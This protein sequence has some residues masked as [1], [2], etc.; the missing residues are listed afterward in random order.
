MYI[1][2]SLPVSAHSVAI[3][4]SCALSLS[5][6]SFA[7]FL[8]IFPFNLFFTSCF[9]S[10][11]S[12]AIMPFS[13]QILQCL[14][15]LLSGSLVVVSVPLSSST[16]EP[17]SENPLLWRRERTDFTPAAVQL[18]GTPCYNC[19]QSCF[20]QTKTLPFLTADG[21]TYAQCKAI[22]GCT[23]SCDRT[24]AVPAATPLKGTPCYNCVQS[25]FDQTGTFPFY[26]PDGFTYDQCKAI[27]GCTESC[28]IVD[29]SLPAGPQLSGPACRDCVQ[30][31]F[32]RTG[33][34]P[35]YT[36]E[37]YTYDQCRAIGG[38]TTC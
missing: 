36:A 37:G 11:S 27:G 28:Q 16:S 12:T 19:A 10:R 14:T 1:F 8:A 15:L 7:S 20:E 38:C 26:T 18:K 5:R 21:F 23:E 24:D 33:E 22:G 13:I 29:S 35:F 4:F 32:D 6:R 17:L 3:Y 34:F 9:C 2:N 25:C 31:C 30:D